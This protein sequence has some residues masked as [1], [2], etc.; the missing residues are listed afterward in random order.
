MLINKKRR[1]AHFKKY[2]YRKYKKETSKK[3]TTKTETTHKTNIHK[4]NNIIKRV[5]YPATY[6]IKI[7]KK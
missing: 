5:K 1:T 4:R 2:I 6:K 7:K 3:E